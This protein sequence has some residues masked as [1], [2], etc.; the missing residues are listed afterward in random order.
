MRTNGRKGGTMTG[1]KA[2]ALVAAAV[3]LLPVSCS[4][5][6][7]WIKTY[8]TLEGRTEKMDLP[9]DTP[10]ELEATVRKYRK[11]VEEKVDAGAKEAYYLRL[12]GSAYL[13]RRMYGEALKAFEASAALTPANAPLFYYMGLCSGYVG[14][15]LTGPDEGQKSRAYVLAAER[16]HLRALE[17]DPAYDRS[18][19]ALAVLY[20]FELGRPVEAASLAER[21]LKINTEDDGARFVLARAYFLTGRIDEAVAVYGVIEEKSKNPRSREDAKRNRE[22]ILSDEGARR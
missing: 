7:D 10:E 5:R 22:A 4:K 17:L 9:P 20:A 11:T 2:L 14:K 13:D 19:Y 18:M 8:F 6:P 12:L 1:R 15:S 16:N 21:Y 3:A